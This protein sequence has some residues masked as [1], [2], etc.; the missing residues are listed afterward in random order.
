[1]EMSEQ[2][3]TREWA[4]SEERIDSTDTGPSVQDE[5]RR[6]LAVM[7]DRDTGGVPA[8]LRELRPGRR[9]RSPDAAQVDPHYSSRR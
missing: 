1:M 8:H 3:R 7:G 6:I 5:A 9:G 4:V 2:D